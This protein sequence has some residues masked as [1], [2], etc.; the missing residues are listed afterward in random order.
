MDAALPRGCAEIDAFFCDDFDRD[1]GAPVALWQGNG[2]AAARSAVPGFSL[3][4]A[5]SVSATPSTSFL[6]ADLPAPIGQ[7]DRAVFSV[8]LN[9]QPPALPAGAMDEI[10]LLV[11]GPTHINQ[12]PHLRIVVLRS[13]LK[14]VQFDPSVVDGGN[15]Y[16]TVGQFPLVP[17]AWL[18]IAIAVDWSSP[19]SVPHVTVS[20]NGMLTLAQPL[21]FANF[22]KPTLPAIIV[23]AF[24]AQSLSGPWSIA[25][26]DV[27]FE[28][29]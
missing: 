4:W 24:Y 16:W 8:A 9:V 1:G 20:V 3:P 28:T 6:A 17:N 29:R 19:S 10:G 5:L 26:D 15:P 25:Y 2:D 22:P 7:P 23:G 13:E 27:V 12:Q 11:F 21:H 14:L 18:E